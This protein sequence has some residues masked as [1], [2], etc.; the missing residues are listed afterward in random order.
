MSKKKEI[1]SVR[2]A[3]LAKL[4]EVEYLKDHGNSKKGDKKMMHP[5]TALGM[6]AHKVIK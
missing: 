3:F 2:E 4:I 6:R 1:A 5:N